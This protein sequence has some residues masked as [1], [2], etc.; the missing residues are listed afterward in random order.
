MKYYTIYKIT[1]NPSNKFYI[2]RHIT[3]NLND[4]YMGSGKLITAAIKKYGADQFTKTYISIFSEE[5]LMYEKEAELVTEEFCKREDTYN[6]APGGFGGGWRHINSNVELRQ[7]KNKKARKIANANGALEKAAERYKENRQK[8]E[9]NPNR[10]PVCNN[11]IP[12][13]KRNRNTYC[14][15]SCQARITNKTRSLHKNKAI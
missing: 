13:L 2:G 15:S 1:H 3:D 12:Y 4:S 10:C 7:Q 5:H 8:Y 6:V 11:N 14:S 9:N